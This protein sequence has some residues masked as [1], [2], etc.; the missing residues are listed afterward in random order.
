MIA[1]EEEEV[2]RVLDL[3]S[4]EQTDDFEGLLPPVNVIPEKKVVGLSVYFL[5]K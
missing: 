5:Q 4:K 2:F 1:T 3:I